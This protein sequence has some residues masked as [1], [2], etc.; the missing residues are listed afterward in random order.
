M[1]R[2]AIL[3]LVMIFALGAYMVAAPVVIEPL[4]DEVKS[5]QAVE[6]TGIGVGVV[7]SIFQ[8]AFVGVPVG[9]MV[10]VFVYGFAWLLRLER[11]IGGR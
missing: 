4:G 6:E 1:L 10:V 11:I 2:V 7:D 8:V 3:G 9:F 5:S